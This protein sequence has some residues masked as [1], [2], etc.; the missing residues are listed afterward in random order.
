MSNKEIEI[1]EQSRFVLLNNIVASEVR[2]GKTLFDISSDMA[3][4]DNS[5]KA[6]IGR[7]AEHQIDRISKTAG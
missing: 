5:F 6:V 1:S 3:N 2:I 7:I 4:E